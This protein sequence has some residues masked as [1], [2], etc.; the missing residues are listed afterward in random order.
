MSAASPHKLV[1]LLFE[2]LLD[3]L[4]K[5]QGAMA[6]GETELKCS[7]LSR[8]VRIVDEGLRSALNR[9]QGGQLASD[10]GD[11][12][13]YISLRLTQANLRNDPALLDECKRLIEPIIE[14]WVAI[15]PQVGST[16]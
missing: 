2:G 9:E 13:A 7:V 4:A 16:R 12:Y 6:Q 3:C 5:A 14:A 10:L 8:A 1:T 15:G 11:L